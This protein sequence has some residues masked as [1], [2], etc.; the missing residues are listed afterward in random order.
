MDFH[1]HFRA[2]KHVFFDAQ[3]G[4]HRIFIFIVRQHIN[5]D[6]CKNAQPRNSTLSLPSD[7]IKA[8]H[9]EGHRRRIL[10]AAPTAFAAM[11]NR[12]PD[13]AAA[14]RATQIGLVDKRVLPR[15]IWRG[16]HLTL[17]T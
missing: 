2:Q 11:R 9:E 7:A 15:M 8:A 4:Y 3:R 16:C 1:E 17:N 10:A 13:P 14:L 12:D 5:F 6:I